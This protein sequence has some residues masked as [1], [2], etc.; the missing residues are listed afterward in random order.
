MILPSLFKGT[1][2]LKKI[3]SEKN[4]LNAHLEDLIMVS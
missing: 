3:C 1:L 4:Y 2:R